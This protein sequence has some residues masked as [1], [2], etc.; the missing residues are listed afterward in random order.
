MLAGSRPSTI[1]QKTHVARGDSSAATALIIRARRG[2]LSR[3][4]AQRGAKP[5]EVRRGYLIVVA[6]NPRGP[7]RVCHGGDSDEAAGDRA[8]AGHHDGRPRGEG[9]AEG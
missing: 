5:P 4:G 9:A 1:W 3:A 7:R 2:A 6:V 8:A